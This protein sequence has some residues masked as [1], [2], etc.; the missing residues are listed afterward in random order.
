M[1]VGIVIP[2]FNGARYLRQCIDS[3]LSQDHPRLR[4]L[5][6][7]G[8]SNDA[9]LEVI[10]SYGQKI[11]WISEPDE[12]QADAIRKGFAQLDTDLVGWLNSDDLLI[13]GAV[14]RVVRAAAEHPEAVL[15][16]GNVEMV[17]EHGE[18]ISTA[19]AVDIDHE[20]M[21]LGR[22]RALQPGSFYRRDAV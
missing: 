3:V 21:R 8:G 9:S 16:H 4:C 17:D 22:G 6:M 7:D 19:H 12:G 18:H 15:F 1:R 13:Q 20:S 14:S 10:R 11:E 2:N 5:V